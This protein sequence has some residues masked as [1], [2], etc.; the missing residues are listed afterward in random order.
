MRAL[1]ASALLALAGLL[2]AAMPAAAEEPVVRR[3]DVQPPAHMTVGDRATYVITIES[4]PGLEFSLIQSSLPGYLEVVGPPVVMTQPAEDGR[5]LVTLTFELAAFAPGQL[6]VPP[7]TL[8]YFGLEVAGG[9][10]QTPPSMLVVDSV[11]PAEPALPPPRDLKP[12]AFIGAP[13]AGWVVPALAASAATLA[14]VVLL[15]YVRVRVLRRRAAPLPAPV[16]DQELPEDRARGVLDTAGASFGLEGDYIEYYSSIGTTVRQY[17]TDRYEFPA[18][19][20]TTRELEAEMLKRGLDRWQV[21]VASGLL[22]QCDAVVYASY[23][24][25]AERADAD[26]TAAY[27]IVEMSRPQPVEEAVAP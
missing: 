4:D 16:L 13:A 24:P 12:Q 10:L 14:L 23:R 19:A 20:L 9:E 1:L 6:E 8:R 5:V 3:V 15:I 26:L 25:A 21:R 22:E 2:M 7:M 27:E 11:L 17:L 18:F